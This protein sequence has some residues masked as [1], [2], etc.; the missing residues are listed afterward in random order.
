MQARTRTHASTH[1]HT[2]KHTHAHTRA[3]IYVHTHIHA[4]VQS[5][6]GSKGGRHGYMGAV[7]GEHEPAVPPPPHSAPHFPGPAPA[8][9]E[10]KDRGVEAPAQRGPC[11]RPCSVRH[12]EKAEGGGL[13]CVCRLKVAQHPLQEQPDSEGVAPS[14]AVWAR[15]GRAMQPKDPASIDHLSRER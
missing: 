7:W 5:C 3:H 12:V 13:P 6:R 15:R 1:A 14:L 11:D 2:R 10:V 9:R 8:P 4:C